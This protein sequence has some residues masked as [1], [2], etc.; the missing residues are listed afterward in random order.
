V[1]GEKPRSAVIN[2]T[3]DPSPKDL[4]EGATVEKN[5]NI[6]HTFR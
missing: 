3:P 4:A 1:A 2:L 6:W 5:G